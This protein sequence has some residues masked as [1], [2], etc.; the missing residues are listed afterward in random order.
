M[1]APFVGMKER[2]AFVAILLFLFL[3]F[4]HADI[5]FTIG[6][7]SSYLFGH[8]LDF[9]DFNKSAYGTVPYL[10]STYALFALWGLPLRLFGFLHE[11]A[12]PQDF[13]FFWYKALTKGCF[14]AVAFFFGKT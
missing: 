5:Q 3:S 11:G 14:V 9:Y 10:P 13:I 2:V 1:I 7:S 8:I 6:C 4:N 12:L